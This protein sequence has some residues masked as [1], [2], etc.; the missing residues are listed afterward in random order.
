MKKA[1]LVNVVAQQ[2]GITKRAATI[3]VN[4]ILEQIAKEPAPKAAIKK[5]PARS[6]QR[7]KRSS[8]ATRSVET[9]ATGSFTA[10]KRAPRAAGSTPKAGSAKKAPASELTRRRKGDGG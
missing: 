4:T 9:S 1:D 6:L 5:A 3:A 10:P 7:P 8:G 2:A